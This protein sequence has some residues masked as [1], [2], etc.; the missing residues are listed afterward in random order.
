PQRLRLAIEVVAPSTQF[1]VVLC[2]AFLEF[3]PIRLERTPRF[4]DDHAVLLERHLPRALIFRLGNERLCPRRQ[5]ILVGLQLGVFLGKC[6]RSLRE[7]CLVGRDASLPRREFLGQLA[8]RDLALFHGA[9][10][11]FNGSLE[12]EEL[13]LIRLEL[14]P[15][16]CSL[17]RISAEWFFAAPSLV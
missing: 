16:S 9:D 7:S 13:S 15:A 12:L 5:P 2:S 10:P 11:A 3:S 14:L 1:L 8:H 17:R 6:I 4:L